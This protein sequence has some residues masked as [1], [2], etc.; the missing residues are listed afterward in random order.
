MELKEIDL[1]ETHSILVFPSYLEA[2]NLE[3]LISSLSP[4]LTAND[5]IVVADDSGADYRAL[6]EDSCTRALQGSN[7]RLCFSYSD[8]KN[9][10]GAAVRNA[11]ESAQKNGS[12]ISKF[13]EADSDGSHR[14]DDIIKI[15]RHSSDADLLI[16]SRYSRGSKISGWPISRRI[17][18]KI[19]NLSIPSILGVNSNDLT[20]GLRRY[21][22]NAIQVMLSEDAKNKGFIYLSETAY[23][24][25]QADLAVEDVPIHFENRLFGE[26]TV[27]RSEIFNSLSGLI[28]LVG[29]RL[30][31]V[32]GL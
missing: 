13:L 30:K 2:E 12:T 8:A 20:N 5:L 31:N 15:L 29:L 27:G 4:F 32:V 22:Q 19:L 17:F 7:G 26:S 23:L 24:I 25:A 6:L 10:R 14:P 9:G 18:S 1:G 16:G 3:I 11:F 28:R 21:N